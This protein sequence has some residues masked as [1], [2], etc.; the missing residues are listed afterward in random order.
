TKL[1]AHARGHSD[2]STT[3]KAAACGYRRP[4]NCSPHQCHT[5]VPEARSRSAYATLSQ[6]TGATLDAH[7]EQSTME[8]RVGGPRCSCS[9][10][11]NIEQAVATSQ[12]LHRTALRSCAAGYTGAAKTVQS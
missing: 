10:D 11:H 6:P 3:G 8:A 2:E 5:P 7:G 1:Q 12:R 4:A 9:E